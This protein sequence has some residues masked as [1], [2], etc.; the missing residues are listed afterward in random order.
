MKSFK[1]QPDRSNNDN[2][3][4]IGLWR[5]SNLVLPLP[6]A[7]RLLVFTIT[8]AAGFQS[9]CGAGERRMGTMQVKT[10]QSSLFL[11]RFSHFS[12]INVQIAAS[13]WLLVRVLKGLIPTIFANILIAF[14]ENFQRFLLCHYCWHPLHLNWETPSAQSLYLLICYSV[15]FSDFKNFNTYISYF[16]WHY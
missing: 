11:L 7:S 9:Y 3:L 6:G 5:C 2:C 8:G 12:W 10:L 14:M 13:L 16:L 15:Y 1:E 4:R